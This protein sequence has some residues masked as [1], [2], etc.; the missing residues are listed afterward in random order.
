LVALTQTTQ[1]RKEAPVRQK[2]PWLCLLLAL[3]GCERAA[4][5]SNYPPDPIL[6]NKGSVEGKPQ[7]S[8]PLLAHAEPTMPNAPATAL[9]S[10][11]KR[12]SAALRAMARHTP[13]QSE[14]PIADKDLT[15]PAVASKEP[16]PSGPE[17][18]PEPP[19]PAGRAP[20]VTAVPAVRTHEGQGST[21]EAKPASARREVVGD[22]GHGEDHSW[23][24][25]VLDRHYQGPMHLRY[26]DATEDD[27][28]GG[29]VCLDPDP[30]LSEFKEGDVV[31]LEGELVRENGK[32]LH[33]R[34]NHFPRYRVTSVRLVRSR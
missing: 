12:H 8:R 11:P 32:V 21:V 5:R 23:L 6:A 27:A 13:P 30:R 28:W 19:A 31:H 4:V 9:A 29:K 3:A 15:P 24:Q 7:S 20:T 10:A 17:L 25:G 14:P 33:G 2:L 34:W 18:T 22:Y 16:Q 1:R 26:C